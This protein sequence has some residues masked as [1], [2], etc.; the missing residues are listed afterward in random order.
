MTKEDIKSLLE[1]GLVG[2]QTYIEGDDG[3][4]FAARVVFAGFAGLNSV[5]RHQLVYGALGGHMGQ[6]IHALSIQ[7][8][9]PEE[10]Q[11][12]QPFATL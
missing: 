9:T 2:A 1:A 7:T 4:H 5:K 10:W 3:V 8:Y 11:Q 12:Q 6:A